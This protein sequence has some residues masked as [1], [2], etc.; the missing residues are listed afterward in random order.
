VPA[1][2]VSGVVVDQSGAPLAGAM[3]SLL[4]DASTGAPFFAAGSAR[5]APD[6]TFAIGDVPAGRYR[7]NA[8][9]PTVWSSGGSTGGVVSS[10]SVARPGRPQPIEVVVT[11][12]DVSGLQAVVR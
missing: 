1:H 5:T 7:L 6:G 8:S 10:T 4:A 12:A 3:V 2:N 11:E 9:V